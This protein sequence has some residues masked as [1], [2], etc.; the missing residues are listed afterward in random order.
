MSTKRLFV[1]NLPFSTTESDL[2][3]HFGD[4]QPHSAKIIPDRG[5][6]FVDIEGDQLDACVEAMNG[7][8]L[9]GRTLRVNEAIPQEDRPRG[10]G[11]GGYRGGGGGDRGDRGGY[12]GDRDR[13]DRRGGGRY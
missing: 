2:L 4:F 7:S 10:G 13:N 9:G 12:R 1:G 11:G 3:M 8:Q 6:G 5:F